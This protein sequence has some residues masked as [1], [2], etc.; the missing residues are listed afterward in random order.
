[1]GKNELASANFPFMI[2]LP[3]EFVNSHLEESFRKKQT[4]C[5][6]VTVKPLDKPG[7]FR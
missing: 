2:L 4:L 3:V 5:D 6:S 1:M 7:I